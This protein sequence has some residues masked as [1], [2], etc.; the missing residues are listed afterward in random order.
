MRRNGRKPVFRAKGVVVSAALF[1]VFVALFGALM[2]QAGTTADRE[3]TEFLKTAIR[4]AAVT[5]YAVDG[6][7]PASLEEI[8]RLYGVIVDTDRFIVRYN[9]FAAN[10]MPDIT[11]IDK[12]AIA[13]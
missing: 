13:P 1:L 12:G 10:I 7:Y 5:H 3:Q 6:R 2:G 8:V 4:N 9:I 11:V